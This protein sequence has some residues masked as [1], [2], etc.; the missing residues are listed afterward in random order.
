MFHL[1]SHLILVLVSA[2]VGKHKRGIVNGFR[3][4]MKTRTGSKIHVEVGEDGKNPKCPA[5]RS[6]LVHEIGS[7]IRDNVPMIATRYTKLPKDQWEVVPRHLSVRIFFILT[8]F[9]FI[10]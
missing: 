9:I 3:L 4:Q 5:I 1:F 8:S 2:Y 7:C 10:C 6:L